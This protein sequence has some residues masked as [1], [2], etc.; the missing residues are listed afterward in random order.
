M[1][2]VKA[3]WENGVFKPKEPV[4]LEERT[5]VD[6]VIP[7][8]RTEND[9]PT[10]WKAMRE[11]IGLAKDAGPGTASVDH[12]AKRMY[13][14]DGKTFTLF[15][16]RVGC[17]ATEDDNPLARK[18]ELTTLTDEVRAQHASVYA[19]HSLCDLQNQALAA[20]FDVLAQRCD[21]RRVP[22]ACERAL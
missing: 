11:F 19:W 9:D 12:D 17:Y 16:Q 2:T 15:A 3:V 14:Y 1:A 13:L 4:Q 7:A 18:L 10:G 20:C 5:E 6:V 22:S 8:S 21:R